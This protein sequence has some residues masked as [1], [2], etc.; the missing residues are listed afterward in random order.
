MVRNTIVMTADT[1]RCGCPGGDS[2]VDTRDKGGAI[3]PGRRLS[4]MPTAFVLFLAPLALPT[5]VV[6]L[7]SLRGRPTIGQAG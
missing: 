5:F 6:V 7:V 2:G 3:M 1:A 4:L